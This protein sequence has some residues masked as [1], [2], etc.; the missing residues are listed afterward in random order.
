LVVIITIGLDSSP[1]LYRVI[2]WQREF[3][4]LTGNR[5]GRHGLVAYQHVE[6]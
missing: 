4:M 1:V 3:A 5:T 2:L 6:G